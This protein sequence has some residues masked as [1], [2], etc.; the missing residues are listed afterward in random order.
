FICFLFTA[1]SVGYRFFEGFPGLCRAIGCLCTIS[2]VGSLM[3]LS[4]MSCNRYILI[5]HNTLYRRV[6]TLRN[7]LLMCAGIHLFG[8]FLVSLNFY[9]VGN[10]SFDRKSFECV[11]DRMASHDYTII[12]GIVLVWVPTIVTGVAYSRTYLFVRRARIK[13]H[14]HR[15]AKH[16]TI[17]GN[18]GTM[19]SLSHENP[20]SLK[21]KSAHKTETEN[22]T[23]REEDSD[24]PGEEGTP[25]KDDN[26]TPINT[27]RVRLT[28]RKNFGN[29]SYPTTARQRALPDLASLKLAKTLFIIY[30]V[31]STCWFPYSAVIIFDR[32]DHFSHEVHAFVI[33]FAHLNASINW[34]VY[35]TTHSKL[36]W[37][38]RKLLGLRNRKSEAHVNSN[39]VFTVS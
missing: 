2:C 23:S 13:V 7:C 14:S 32:Y 9:G 18:S 4:T 6:F 37:A 30:V 36:R 28:A 17:T 21:K 26:Q 34:L 19:S 27:K 25:R 38:F 22:S 33:V 3:T 15:N 31:F 12:F 11:W 20:I 10:H 29:S 16:G 35:Y 5:C 39:T 24:M 8:F 1:K